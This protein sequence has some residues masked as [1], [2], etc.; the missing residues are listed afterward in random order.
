MESKNK[1]RGKNPYGAK[2]WIEGYFV[3]I[4]EKSYIYDDNEEYTMKENM[5]EVI[6]ETVSQFTGI[7]CQFEGIVDND[8]GDDVY[9]NAVVECYNDGEY[10]TGIVKWS[11]EDFRFY[12]EMANGQKWSL[13]KVESVIGDRFEDM[14]L[15]F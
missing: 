10:E 13:D 3:K 6:P 7:M 1:F 5:R 11:E 9:E 2:I 4:G 14:H 8:V 12:V 15:V